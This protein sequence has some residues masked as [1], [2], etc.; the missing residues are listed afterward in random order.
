MPLRSTDHTPASI[1]GVIRDQTNAASA[2]AVCSPSAR[3]APRWFVWLGFIALAAYALFLGTHTTVV[4][5]GSDSSGYL[6][7][8]R[9]LTTGRL[10]TE[11]RVPS[12]FGVPSEVTRKHFS[13]AGFNTF[14]GNPHLAPVYPIGLPLHF[15]LAGKLLGGNA[16]PFLVQLLAAVG[17][18]G[19]CYR[20]S[21]ELGIDYALSA[22]GAAMLAVFPVF[23]FTSIQT[24]SDTLA[25]TWTLVALLCGLR[26][27]VSACWAIACGAAL[28]IGVLVRPTN[29]AVAP[30]L[31]VLIGLNVR[32]LAWFVAGG[33]PGAVW[34]AFYNHQ[35]FGGALRSG[36]GNIYADFGLQHFG[37]G[38]RHFIRWI[39][40]FLPA[41]TLAF[42]IAALMDRPGRKRELVALLLAAVA[43]IGLYLFYE[44]FRED[45]WCLRYILPAIAALIPAGLL[46][47]EA[48]ARGPGSRWP[49][50]FRPAL[51]L[52]LTV[53]AVGNSW[54]WTKRLSVFQVPKYER[55]YADAAR[56]VRAQAPPGALVVCAQLSG[57]LYYYTDLPTLIFDAITP[58]EFAQYTLRARGATRAI[59]AVLFDVEEERA[60][61]TYCPGS[62]KRVSSVA[63]ISIWVLP[64]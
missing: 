15:A 3:P 41:P 5:G 29:L 40:L 34:L 20:L 33:V 35:L 53:W 9:L 10:Q 57:A 13:P 21:R 27:R 46:G 14:P 31:I 56:A 19:L 7:S 42:P 23:I 43:F 22:A 64:E 36:Y 38:V 50:A 25:T 17:A 18:V 11:V 51:A 48:I 63:N 62:W 12:E 58:E 4:A 60:L 54:Y 55:A 16:G 44:I 26:A 28:A 6:N 45:W 61:R 59:Y 24:L 47:A 30:A 32:R 1:G 49:R 37:P 8:A 39:L 2:N 52:V